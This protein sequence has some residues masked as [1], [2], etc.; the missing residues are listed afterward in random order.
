ME[1]LLHIGK[2]R[3]SDDHLESAETYP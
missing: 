1:E 3:Q 2:L